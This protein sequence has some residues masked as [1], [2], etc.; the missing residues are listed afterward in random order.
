MPP[1]AG[2]SPASASPA[3]SKPATF[4]RSP[5]HPTTFFDQGNA[6]TT[7]TAAPPRLLD[8]HPPAGDLVAEA[9]AGLSEP[10]PTLPCKL[11]YDR[12][13]SH[14]FDRITELDAYYPTRTELAIMRDHA[15]DI[16]DAI[17]PNAYLAEPGSGSSA[18]V[19]LLLDALDDPVA[20]AP[21]EISRK[22]LLESA[23]RL[24]ERYPDIDILPVCA[25]YTHDI[26]LPDAPRPERKRV[27]Y[28]PGSTIGNFRADDARDFL[29]LLADLVGRNTDQP[30][31]LLIGTDLRKDA[32]VLHRAYNDEHGVTAA[33]NVNALLH[34]ARLADAD[35]DAS[36]FTHRAD[37]ND[38]KSRIEMHLVAERDTA[39]TLAGQR[40]AFAAG[41]TIRTELSHKYTRHSFDL[42]AEA[43]EPVG[44]WADERGW[45]AVR[46]YEVR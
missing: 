44:Y 23:H 42:I 1:P 28:F 34:L 25:D 22:H 17:G 4:T 38:A 16:A 32:D 45:F 35:L 36:A 3:R 43:F 14:L 46:Y 9:I 39:F 24:A 20:Y 7:L 19:H 21:I 33:F 29:N 18:K 8:L 2:S 30:G 26:R 12:I 6:I 10:Q 13:G 15:A 37:W 31:G 11:F 5:S 27:A 41:D 40:F